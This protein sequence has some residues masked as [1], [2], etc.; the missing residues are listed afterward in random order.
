[1]CLTV[2]IVAEVCQCGVNGY[3]FKIPVGT[4]RILHPIEVLK[5]GSSDEGVSQYQQGLDE[6]LISWIYNKSG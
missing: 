5:D 1:M 6:L 3:V 2:S 4:R